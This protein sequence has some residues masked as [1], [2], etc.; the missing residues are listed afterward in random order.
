MKDGG[1]GERESEPSGLVSLGTHLHG[2][3]DLHRFHSLGFQPDHDG[4]ADEE[5]WV[6]IERN[7]DCRSVKI[8]VER[9]PSR[10]TVLAAD[11]GVNLGSFHSNP[12]RVSSFS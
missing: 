7:L 2:C 10:A 8:Q 1:V 6:L 11:R 4:L 3:D 5:I 12:I 9:I